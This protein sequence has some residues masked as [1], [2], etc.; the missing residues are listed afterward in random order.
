MVSSRVLSGVIVESKQG[1][2]VTLATLRTGSEV[3]HPRC[4]LKD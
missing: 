2:L 3:C 4:V 1:K